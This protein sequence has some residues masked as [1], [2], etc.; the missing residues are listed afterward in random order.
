[1][2]DIGDLKSSGL[3]PCRFDSCHPYQ[4]GVVGKLVKPLDFHSRVHLRTLRVQPPS[5]SPIYL[6]GVMDNTRPC[7]GLD[8]GSIPSEDAKLCGCVGM[9]DITGLDPVGRN[10]VQVQV[11]SPVPNYEGLV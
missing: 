8:G 10:P 4:Y 11:L 2:E 5:T 9:A 3:V 6:L 1:M 7:E